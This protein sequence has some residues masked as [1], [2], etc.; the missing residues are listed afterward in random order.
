MHEYQN[1][2]QTRRPVILCFVAYYLPGFRSGGPL[3]SIVN[4]VE[5]FGKEFD[6]HIVTSD[7]DL[8][9]CAPYADINSNGWNMVG[10]AKVFYVHTK[11]LNFLTVIGLLRSTRHDVIYLNS[12]FSLSFTAL[13][14]F[15]RRLG[16]VPNMPCVI[17]PRGEFSTG[18]LM[19]KSTK[20]KFYIVITRAIGLYRNLWWQASSE[21]EKIDIE[22]ALPYVRSENICIAKDLAKV[23]LGIVSQSFVQCQNQKE[24]LRVCFLSRISPKKN[25]AFALRILA[26]VNV[27]VIFTVYGPKEDAS[28]WEICEALITELPSNVR[29]LYDGEIHPREVKSKLVKH[30]LFFFPTLGENYGHVIHEALLAGLPVL[31]SDQ[32]PWSD[33][34]SRGVGWTISL[35]EELVFSRRIDEIASWSYNRRSVVRQS[36]TAYATELALDSFV[37]D[38]NRALFI[39]AMVDAK[40]KI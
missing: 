7:R 2:N 9:D 16:L 32:T 26:K 5:Y 20:K 8:Q 25:L 6:I 28:Y 27:E 36:A 13:P 10:N 22:H 33:V 15:F 37:I 30:D 24:G 35:D 31:L 19:L 29:V 34:E 11:R 23:D 18:A 3:R 21:R 4:F 1:K 17:A 40:H 38:S 39:N 12:F 14:L